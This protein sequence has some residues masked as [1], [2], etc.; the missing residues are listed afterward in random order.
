MTGMCP[1]HHA[2]MAPNFSSR[3]PGT[4]LQIFIWHDKKNHVTPA[5]GYEGLGVALPKLACV[6]GV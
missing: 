6:A 3:K 1:P 4:F 5:L 2:N